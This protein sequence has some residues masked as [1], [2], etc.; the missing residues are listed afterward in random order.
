MVRF[1]DGRLGLLL[2]RSD[3]DGAAPRLLGAGR[4]GA[5]LWRVRSDG[6]RGGAAGA[7]GGFDAPGAHRGARDLLLRLPPRLVTGERLLTSPDADESSV[8]PEVATA[9]RLGLALDLSSYKHALRACDL[10]GEWRRALNLLKS[11]REEGLPPDTLVYGNVMNACARNGRA[12]TVLQLSK[13]LVW[14][15]TK[16]FVVSVEGSVTQ[17]HL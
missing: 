2:E 13:K 11:M 10:A 6:R 9:C 1:Y 15:I 7:Q 8:D 5:H 17:Y 14:R 3:G 12:Q 4:V 16:K